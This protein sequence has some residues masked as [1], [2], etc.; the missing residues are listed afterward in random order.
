MAPE[1]KVVD[2]S[3]LTKFCKLRLK[4]VGLLDMLI[5]KTVEILLDKNLIR[6]KS[7]IVNSKHTKACFNQKS[8]KEFLMKK[9]K[10]LRK[11]VIELMKG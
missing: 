11:A 10:L 2:S 4:D 8:P 7:I 5:R 3:S 9:S 6:N 1:D